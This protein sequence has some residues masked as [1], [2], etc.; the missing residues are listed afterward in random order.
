MTVNPDHPYTDPG[1]GRVECETCGKW[2]HLVIHSCK[3]YPVTYEAAMR[4]VGELRQEA[5]MW[6]ER[7]VES[8]RLFQQAVI[9]A[10]SIQSDRD[11]LASAWEQGFIVSHVI[12]RGGSEGWVVDIPSHLVADFQKWN[13]YRDNEQEVL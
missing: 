2:V 4:R 10:A 6:E 9:E 13:P 7:A 3:G 8:K 12:D 1:D 5:A 11:A